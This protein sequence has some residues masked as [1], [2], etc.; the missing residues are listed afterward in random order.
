MKRIIF[1]LLFAVLISFLTGCATFYHKPE[2]RGRII[3]AQTKEPIEDA[4]AVVLYY[5]IPLVGSPGGPNSYVFEANE[6]LTD[7]K[8]EFYF[9]S[10]TS[11]NLFTKDSGIRFIFYKPGYMVGSGLIDTGTAGT[12]IKEELYFATDVVGKEVELDIWSWRL[13]KPIRWK[14]QQGIVEL[15][16]GKGYLSTPADY[17]SNKLPLLYKAINEDRRNRGLKG[18]VK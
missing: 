13:G 17:R 11:L 6:T 2:F 12:Y 5:K 14:G 7:N 16:M 10:L 9:P 18:E 3:D 1:F 8:G 15:K 4:V